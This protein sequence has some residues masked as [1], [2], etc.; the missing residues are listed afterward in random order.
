MVMFAENFKVGALAVF[1]GRFKNCTSSVS[2]LFTSM[3]LSHSSQVLLFLIKLWSYLRV[4]VRVGK[5]EK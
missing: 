4:L 2:S 1:E 3:T 5:T